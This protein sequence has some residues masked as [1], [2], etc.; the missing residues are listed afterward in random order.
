MA[1]EMKVAITSG[2]DQRL[3]KPMR[4]TGG[5][6][7]WASET[8]CERNRRPIHSRQQTHDRLTECFKG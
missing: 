1:K 7:T 8:A 2:N 6:G 5:R 4:D 3:F